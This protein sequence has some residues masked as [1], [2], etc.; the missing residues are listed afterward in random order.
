[1][2]NINLVYMNRVNTRGILH[3]IYNPMD[4]HINMDTSTKQKLAEATRLDK[5]S[6]DLEKYIQII[7]SNDKTK[8]DYTK[9]EKEFS[10]ILSE[11]KEYAH[12]NKNP[13][14]LVEAGILNY[15]IYNDANATYSSINEAENIL[16]SK[17]NESNA[18]LCRL[19]LMRCLALKVAISYMENDHMGTSALKEFLSIPPQNNDEKKLWSDIAH[20]F[21][22]AENFT[23][24]T[25]ILEKLCSFG[26]SVEDVETLSEI[27]IRQTNYVEANTLLKDAITKLNARELE[28]SWVIS[29]VKGKIHLDEAQKTVEKLKKQSP[30]TY[31]RYMA[32]IKIAEA[33][34]TKEFDA[35]EKT[36]DEG[37]KLGFASNLCDAYLSLYRAKRDYPKIINYIESHRSYFNE[38]TADIEEAKAYMHLHN[39]K[40][41]WELFE[42]DLTFVDY[43]NMDTPPPSFDVVMNS[44]DVILATSA[45][46][47]SFGEDLA[48]IENRGNQNEYLKLCKTY[49]DKIDLIELPILRFA[50]L[51]KKIK[52][53]KLNIIQNARSVFSPSVNSGFLANTDLPN[54][55]SFDTLPIVIEKWSS[56]SYVKQMF[57]KAELH[58]LHEDINYAI[59][60]KDDPNFSFAGCLAS[61]HTYVEKYTKPIYY[62]FLAEQIPKQQQTLDE[63]KTKIDNFENQKRD[64][65]SMLKNQSNTKYQRY[66][67]VRDDMKQKKEVLK[68]EIE[69]YKKEYKEQKN[70]LYELTNQR[71]QL[72]KLFQ[73]MIIDEKQA[74]GATKKIINPDFQNFV[75]RNAKNLDT[76]KAPELF[77]LQLINNIEAYRYLR[78]IIVHDDKDALELQLPPKPPTSNKTQFRNWDSMEESQIITKDQFFTLLN[79][80]LFSKNSIF[81]SLRQ[82]NIGE[83]HADKAHKFF[84]EENENHQQEK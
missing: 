70:K 83:M 49:Q 31:T 81:S 2:P 44:N 34:S 20:V 18:E 37:T 57:T 11:I 84:F 60:H 45:L 36:L 8:R 59:E 75:S 28:P 80:A 66:S 79:I 13:E 65:E 51:N 26:P 5:K 23:V 16:K 30:S 61:L 35:I 38:L 43:A 55:L 72:G 41:A 40:K 76:I 78:N 24:S 58:Q 3:L 46:L 63:L 9:A 12:K 7:F 42:K 10:R 53:E 73:V 32:Y 62:Y 21:Y 77:G 19:D 17:L 69:K 71:Y 74:D 56:I 14:Y 15:L 4:K 39:Y 25:K 54:E 22:Q 67:S 47:G 68:Q 52:D 29:C 82:L 48:N 27:Y 64:I 33:V 6:Q 50:I 1:M